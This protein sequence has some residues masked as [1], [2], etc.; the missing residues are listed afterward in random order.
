MAECSVVADV[1]SVALEEGWLVVV[2][3]SASLVGDGAASPQSGLFRGVL[4]WVCSARQASE[5]KLVMPS[6]GTVLLHCLHNLVCAC[7][8]TAVA[9]TPGIDGSS[10]VGV[11]VDAVAVCPDG[12]CCNGC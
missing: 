8:S 5:Q 4:L 10:S 9:N 7:E 3:D 12:C 1:V 11:M 2:D 6:G